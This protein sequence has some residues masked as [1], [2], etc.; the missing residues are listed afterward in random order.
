MRYS[1][2]NLLSLGVF[3]PLL[4][5]ATNWEEPP[6][7]NYPVY[8][9]NIGVYNL[10]GCY[11]RF[12]NP[13]NGQTPI[14]ARVT[15]LDWPT[16]PDD[17]SRTLNDFGNA[18]EQNVQLFLKGLGALGYANYITGCV[19][20][21]YGLNLDTTIVSIILPPG[22]E[23]LEQVDA[24]YETLDGTNRGVQGIF[25]IRTK[26]PLVA[27]DWA[28]TTGAQLK[29]A[30]AQWRQWKPLATIQN[31]DTVTF[32]NSIRSDGSPILLRLKIVEAE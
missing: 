15:Q 3:L 19:I 18:N 1:P 30:I 13:R 16:T 5:S 11:F 24:N 21:Q 26:Q 2:R 27:S 12:Q 31:P 23:K 14:D 7:P 20:P 22:V 25:G 28:Y 17:V 32:V 9:G 29:Q 8:T 6:D 10:H 4:V